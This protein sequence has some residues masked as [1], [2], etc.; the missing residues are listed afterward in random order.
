VYKK[1]LE[2]LIRYTPPRNLSCHHT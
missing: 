2:Q 1:P